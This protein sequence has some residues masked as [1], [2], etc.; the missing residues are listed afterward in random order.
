[1]QIKYNG[2]SFH[3]D[4]EFFMD[5]ADIY[6]WDICQIQYNFMDENYQGGKV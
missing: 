3:D 5:I 2:F 6:D 4:L 1:M